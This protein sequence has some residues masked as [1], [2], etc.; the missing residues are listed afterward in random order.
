MSPLNPD[1]FADLFLDQIYGQEPKGSFLRG[2]LF[3]ICAASAGWII[4]VLVLALE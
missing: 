3:G 1:G 4:A 2:V